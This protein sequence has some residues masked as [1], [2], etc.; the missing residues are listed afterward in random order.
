[1]FGVTIALIAILT[2]MLLLR[3]PPHK[4]DLIGAADRASAALITNEMED[5]VRSALRQ[6][7]DAELHAMIAEGTRLQA[8]LREKEKILAHRWCD[9][10]MLASV[11]LGM[12]QVRIWVDWARQE[13]ADRSSAEASADRLRRIKEGSI[14]GL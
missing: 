11:R 1:M 12:R 2:F 5:R 9:K 8:V 7:S 10:E 4:S 3:V 14:R 6:S 13:C